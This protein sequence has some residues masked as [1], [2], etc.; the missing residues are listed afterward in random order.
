MTNSGCR[1]LRMKCMTNFKSKL[2][3]PNYPLHPLPTYFNSICSVMII[4]MVQI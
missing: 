3:S 1:H 4:I 2:L